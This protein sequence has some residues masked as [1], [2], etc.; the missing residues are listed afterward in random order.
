M[1]LPQFR[2]HNFVAMGFKSVYALFKNIDLRAEVYGFQPFNQIM[3][4]ENN[5]PEYGKNFADRYYIVSGCFVY[6]APFSSMSIC[7]NYYDNAEEP[8]SFNI[9]IGYFIFNKRPFE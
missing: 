8:F 2:A 5:K 1:F 4:T 3:K 9:N 6:H 7:L